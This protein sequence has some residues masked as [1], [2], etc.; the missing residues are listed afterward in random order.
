MPFHL[1]RR[2]INLTI[3]SEMVNEYRPKGS[4]AIWLESKVRHGLLAI[5]CPSSCPVA[6]EVVVVGVVVV[7]VGVCNLSQMRTSKCV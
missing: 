3:L 5:C 1:H 7:V 6:S 2:P 4:D